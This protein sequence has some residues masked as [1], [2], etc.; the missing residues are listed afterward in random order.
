MNKILLFI[1]V[2]VIIAGVGFFVFNLM[3]GSIFVNTQGTVTI[4]K[5]TFN[6]IVA[7][8][9]KDQEIG[10]SNR[11]SLPQNT[12]MLFVFE[13]A[14]F[15][16]FWMKQMK[17]PL[18]LIFINKDHIVTIYPNVQVPTSETDIPT[19]KPTEPADRVLEINAGLA[20]KYG[21]KV[22]DAVEINTK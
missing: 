12:G 11:N 17:F 3:R 2:A 22:G 9:Q 18:D 4:D 14:D 6:V 10:L 16:A 13:N 20:E 19:Y 7:K 1:I 8:D 5:H 15:P 21:F